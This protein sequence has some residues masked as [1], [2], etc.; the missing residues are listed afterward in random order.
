MP[1]WREPEHVIRKSGVPRGT[2]TDDIPFA[3]RKLGYSVNYRVY[4]P[5]G[6]AKNLPVLYVTD[7]SDY[8]RDEMG[9]LVITLDNL[10][11]ER[12]IVPLLVVFIDPWDRKADVNRRE[13][14]LV[15]TADR[16][17]AFC[18]F[19][20]EELV[21]AID[22]SYPTRA[23][24]DSRAIL[25]TSL[26]GLH[27]TYMSTR[28]ASLFG[29]A[30]IQSPSF[31]RAQWVMDDVKKGAPVPLKAFLSAGTFEPP[32]IEAAHDLRDR[33]TRAGADVKYVEVH[34]GH[35][36]GHWRALLDDVLLY[37]FGAPPAHG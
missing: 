15:P 27:A 1:R 8:W 29:L 17:C 12:R 34:E 13:S 32:Q 11:A 10:L 18:D 20:A 35:S 2:L 4:T 9:G 16:T 28:Y 23:A 24:R 5:P 36:W 7:G 33:L 3:S 37:F 14:E 6:S 21:P 30:A 31:R 26:G 25:G 19:I 22:G